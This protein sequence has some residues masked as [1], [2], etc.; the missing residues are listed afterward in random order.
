MPQFL[1]VFGTNVNGKLVVPNSTQAGLSNTATC[2]QL[3]GLV[4]TGIFQEWMGSK[5]TFFWGMVFMAGT[6][7]VAVFAINIQMLYAAEFLMGVPWG[8]FQVS[9]V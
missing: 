6:V 7:F 2:G 5:R 4:L 3:V 1:R 8:M 9:Y